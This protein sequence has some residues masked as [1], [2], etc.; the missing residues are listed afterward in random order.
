MSLLNIDIEAANGRARIALSGELDISSA[1]RV[2]DELTS[3]Q[4]QSPEM[5]VL[6]LR[7]LEF[8]DSTGLRLIVRADEA[9]RAGG[10]RFLIVR[11]PEPVQRVFQIVGLDTRLDMADAPPAP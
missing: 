6:D 7:E 9:A 5:L 11:G 4:A 1:R 3:L 2:E 10:T 8:M